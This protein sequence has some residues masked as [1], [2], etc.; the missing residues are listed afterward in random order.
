M[1]KFLLYIFTSLHKKQ[2]S[3]TEGT[4]IIRCYDKVADYY[5][6]HNTYILPLKFPL[7]ED[8]I[9]RFGNAYNAETNTVY[10]EHLNI[11]RIEIDLH[12]SKRLK[13]IAK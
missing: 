7:S 13:P 12:Q 2:D 9:L 8:E 11:L 4:M 3:D 1:K 5:A 10:L 6:K